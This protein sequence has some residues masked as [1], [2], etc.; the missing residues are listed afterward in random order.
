MPVTDGDGPPPGT[1]G[2]ISNAARLLALLSQGPRF[3]PLKELA[4]EAGLTQPTV[5][6]LLK[7]LVAFGL[8]QQDPRSARYG[9]GPELVRLAATYAAST[10]ALNGIAP[11][12]CDLRNATGST[13]RVAV[14][15][16]TH[17]VDIDRVDGSA[18]GGVFREGVEPRLA[19]RTTEGRLLAARASS[20]VREACAR[21]AQEDVPESQW[22]TWREA[23]FLAE[24][25]GGPMG[26][27]TVA[28][29]IVDASGNTHAVLC[30]TGS[31]DALSETQ[32]STTIP[33]TL[34]RVAER[35]FA[36]VTASG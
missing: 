9:L 28:V 34:S 25:E 6:R 31:S 22:K 3:H 21:A 27:Y 19:L 10:P 32:L 16:G 17:V 36:G 14:L 8:V 33:S 35:A 7:S 11:Y 5:H 4:E 29:P 23:A 30:A 20:D 13:I 15:T 1:L 26:T 12:L 2:T 24:S 18:C